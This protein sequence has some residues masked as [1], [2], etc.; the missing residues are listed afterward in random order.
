M[1]LPLSLSLN[2]T[3]FYRPHLLRVITFAGLSSHVHHLF[4]N[5]R[6]ITL[7]HLCRARIQQLIKQPS[8]QL[9]SYFT[10]CLLGHHRPHHSLA[11]S[12][13]IQADTQASTAVFTVWTTV[14]AIFSWL[15]VHSALH[16][17]AL[18]ALCALQLVISTHLPSSYLNNNSS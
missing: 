8:T 5:R 6:P 12:S 9:L 16:R 11:L 10:E 2:C 3:P 13:P 1:Q 15:Q 7:H 14:P 18:G 17:A 4:D